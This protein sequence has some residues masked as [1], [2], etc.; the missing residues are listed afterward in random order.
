MQRAHPD[1]GSLRQPEDDPRVAAFMD[2][3]DRV[4]RIAES[5][6][7]CG[8]RLKDDG[9][10]ATGI[11]AGAAFGDPDTIVNTSVQESP[12]AL[13]R[14]VWQTIQG[15]FHAKKWSWFRPMATPHFV[16]WWVPDGH[17]P[18]LVEAADRLGRLARQDNTNSAFS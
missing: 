8:W 10:D 16:M 2:N 13:E 4:N 7:G 1:V 6:P 14:L 3:L 12:E 15:R 18:D 9:G 11:D 17:E 5:M